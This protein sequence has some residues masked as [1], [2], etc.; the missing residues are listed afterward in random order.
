MLGSVPEERADRALPKAACVLRTLDDAEKIEHRFP[1]PFGILRHKD[2][3]ERALTFRDAVNKIIHA[4]RYI[5]HADN[6]AAVKVECIGDDSEKWLSARI[7]FVAFA[8]DI[9]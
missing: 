6:L 7:D 4:T 2:N 1:E 3:T 8:S 5:S 9:G